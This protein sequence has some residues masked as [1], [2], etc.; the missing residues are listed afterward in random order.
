MNQCMTHLATDFLPAPAAATQLM[1]SI[2]VLKQGWMN[3][4][5]NGLSIMPW[6]LKAIKWEK[7][8]LTDV[9]GYLM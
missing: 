6:T 5:I 2:T 9:R 1:P 8:P 7:E 4:I 3:I